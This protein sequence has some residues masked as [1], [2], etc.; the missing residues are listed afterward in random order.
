M[1]SKGLPTAVKGAWWSVRVIGNP[2]PLA[3]GK[4]DFEWE[5]ILHNG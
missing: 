2:S 3:V 1:P 4:L 5:D